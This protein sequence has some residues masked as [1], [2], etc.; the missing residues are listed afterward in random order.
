MQH[1]NYQAGLGLWQN[2]NCLEF[3]MILGNAKA[4]TH[5]QVGAT[6][7]KMLMLVQRSP[8]L[9]TSVYSPIKRYMVYYRFF[10]V[11][12]VIMSRLLK[13]IR[14]ILT[15]GLT[16]FQTRWSSV[17]FKGSWTPCSKASMLQSLWTVFRKCP[18]VSSAG[19]RSTVNLRYL[20][21]VITV[22]ILNVLFKT[23]I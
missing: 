19:L 23:Q 11:V 1:P 4:S 5:H 10:F 6:V 2:H 9:N 12:A 15:K 8:P 20:F 22:S 21:L 16:K 3:K 7:L 18:L 14:I 13:L 17:Y